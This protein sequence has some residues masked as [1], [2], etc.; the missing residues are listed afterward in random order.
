MKQLGKIYSAV[1]PQKIEI[2]DKAVFVASN[3]QPYSKNLE[4]HLQEGYEYDCVEYTKDEYI[5][6]LA[7]QLEAAKILLGVE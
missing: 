5:A 7:S 2:T 3:I 6:S 4:G 1:E